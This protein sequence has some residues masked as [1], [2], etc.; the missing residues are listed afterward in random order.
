V[1]VV[2]GMILLVGERMNLVIGIQIKGEE[3][4]VEVA[5]MEVGVLMT[6]EITGN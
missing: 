5:D 1:A 4:P 6:W 3:F 2:D